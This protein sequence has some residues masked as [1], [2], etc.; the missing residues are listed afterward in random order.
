MN[1]FWNLFDFI[2]SDE[3]LISD[4]K[5]QQKTK[6]HYKNRISKYQDSMC[7]ALKIKNVTSLFELEMKT[8]SRCAKQY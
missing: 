6:E 3:K 7:R 5:K 2:R 1:V 4:K 8:Q